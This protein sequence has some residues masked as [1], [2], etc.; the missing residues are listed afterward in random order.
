MTSFSI[1]FSWNGES[2]E[3]QLNKYNFTQPQFHIKFI[4]PKPANLGFDTI[5]TWDP[6]KSALNFGGMP[7]NQWGAI[8]TKEIAASCAEKGIRLDK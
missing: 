6:A 2:F 5:F 3:A 4:E 1:S 8:I 7:D